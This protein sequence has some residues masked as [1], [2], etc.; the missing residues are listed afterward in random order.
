MTPELFIKWLDEEIDKAEKWSDRE[1]RKT[2]PDQSFHGRV[3]ALEEVKEKFLT[4]SF[5]TTTPN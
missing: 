4:I 1:S 2:E 3:L 5:I